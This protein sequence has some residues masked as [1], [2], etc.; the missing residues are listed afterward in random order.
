MKMNADDDVK[1]TESG[2]KSIHINM[3]RIIIACAIPM[4]AKLSSEPEIWLGELQTLALH[5]ADRSTFS[6]AGN[7]APDLMKAAV[8]ECLEEFFGGAQ[9][10]L[11]K[12]PSST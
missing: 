6:A 11:K 4:M 3:L 1:I 12:I 9:A 10:T 8:I 2:I 7:I 5:S